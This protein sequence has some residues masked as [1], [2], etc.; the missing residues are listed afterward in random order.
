MKTAMM[1]LPTAELARKTGTGKPVTAGT[2]K[3][4]VAPRSS[5]L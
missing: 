2:S 5:V 4:K 3:N 1:R